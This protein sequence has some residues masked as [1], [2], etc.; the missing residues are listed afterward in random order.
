MAENR[1]GQTL[2][3]VAGLAMA[4]W[5]G[6]ND[7]A[8]QPPPGGGGGGVGT[9][10]GVGSARQVG[11]GP[12]ARSRVE[13]SCQTRTPATAAITRMAR[14]TARPRRRV[15]DGLPAATVRF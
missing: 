15:F 6:G 5:I 7:V 12:D 8:G 2:R 14:T 10:V 13:R 9:E 11:E 3:L 1:T 4:L